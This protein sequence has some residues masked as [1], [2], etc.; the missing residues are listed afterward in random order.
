MPR[1]PTALPMPAGLVGYTYGSST[2]TNCYATGAVKAD[3]TH[4]TAW[5]GGLVG[6]GG[7]NSGIGTITNSVALNPWAVRR[8]RLPDCWRVCLSRAF[9]C[10]GESEQ[11]ILFFIFLGL[12]FVLIIVYCC[13]VSFGRMR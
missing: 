12:F 2:I 5:A 4:Y 1:P 13:V 7:V 6:R 9:C 3:S 10:G 8:R 11:G